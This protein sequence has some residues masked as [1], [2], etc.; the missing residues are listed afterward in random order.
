[1]EIRLNLVL[2]VDLMNFFVVVFHGK[3]VFHALAQRMR[4]Y[5]FCVRDQ[6]NTYKLL[7]AFSIEMR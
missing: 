5:S 2:V 1:M 6:K 3:L 7:N 4:E